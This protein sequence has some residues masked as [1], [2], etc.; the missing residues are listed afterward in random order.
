M[1]H[2]DIPL[3]DNA[4]DKLGLTAPTDRIA[5]GV[6]ANR[7]DI[8]FGRVPCFFKKKGVFEDDVGIFFGIF[9]G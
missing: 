2:A 1:I 4:P 5:M 7:E 9:S 6:G 3:M 8:I